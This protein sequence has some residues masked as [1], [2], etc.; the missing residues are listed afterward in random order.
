VPFTT[1]SLLAYMETE[2]GPVLVP[3]G[4][5]QSDALLEAVS[6]TADLLGVAIADVDDDLKLRII[7]RWLAWRAALGAAVGQYDLTSFPG[8]SLKRSQ[9][10]AHIRMMLAMAEAAALRYE[11]VAAILAS[12][13]T[14]YVTSIG[15][16][17]DPYAYPTTAEGW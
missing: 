2:V 15:T 14:A 4:L 17:T 7:G 13:S 8:D 9:L 12:S 10:F 11:E 6:E 16:V 3:L 5:D 1:S